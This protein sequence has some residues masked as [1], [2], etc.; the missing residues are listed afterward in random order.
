MTKVGKKFKSIASNGKTDNLI[1][2]KKTKKIQKD[3]DKLQVLLEIAKTYNKGKDRLSSHITSFETIAT[4]L[5]KVQPLLDNIDN[6]NN[7]LKILRHGNSENHVVNIANNINNELQN[8]QSQFIEACK[9]IVHVPHQS[10]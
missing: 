10:L 6:N 4:D 5:D 7:I 2:Q 9:R 1:T 3:L 8:K